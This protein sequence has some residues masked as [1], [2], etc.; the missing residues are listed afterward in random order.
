MSRAARALA[1][2]L[3]AMG[4]VGNA[5]VDAPALDAEMFSTR[6]QPVLAARC[7]T[8]N[9][10]GADRR[11]LPVY[12]PGLF[13][14]DP[15]RVHRDEPL[16]PEELRAN[17]RSA[18]AFA[19]EI[20]PEDSLLVTKPLARVP[21]LGGRVFVLPDDDVDALVVWLGTGGAL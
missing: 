1:L 12:A 21:H 7:A 2:A 15:R 9:C 11:R 16:T 13:R 10:H 19:L 5:H 17:Q 14:A 6:V 18:E 8:P 4:C 20:A 3:G